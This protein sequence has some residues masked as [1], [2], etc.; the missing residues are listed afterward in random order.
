[1]RAV[2]LIPPEERRGTRRA[3]RTGPLSH[4]LVGLLIAAVAAVTALVLT[5][6]TI[7][8]RESEVVRLEQEQAELASQAA[9]LEPFTAFRTLEQARTQTVTSLAKSRFDWE[10]VLRELSL[11]LPAD[12]WLINLTGTVSSQ[13]DLDDGAEIV[14]RDSVEGP[15]LEIVGCAASQDSVGRFLAAL[16]DIDG[17][18]RVTATKSERPDLSSGSA[19]D[20]PETGAGADDDC[21]T[22]DFIVRFEIVAAFDEV[23]LDPAELPPVGP[24]AA[25]APTPVSD[26]GGVGEVEQERAAS[27]EEVESTAQQGAEAASAVPGS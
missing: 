11:V 22:R 2:N 15:A 3:A 5:T 16:S 21:R 18:T 4:L 26:D 14:A 20:E 25:P 13:V 17:V 12:V 24:P 7:S 19:T 1:M 8:D 10:R 9:K 6:N 27:G 23:A